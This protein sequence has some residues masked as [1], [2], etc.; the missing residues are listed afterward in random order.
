MSQ[1]ALRKWAFGI[2]GAMVIP[3]IAWAIDLGVRVAQIEVKQANRHDQVI[4]IKEDLK[5]IK[6]DIKQILHKIKP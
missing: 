5:E 4:E 6:Q 3:V 2:L 1:A